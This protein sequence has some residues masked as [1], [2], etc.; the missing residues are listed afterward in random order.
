MMS[1]ATYRAHDGKLDFQ[2]VGQ[3]SFTISDQDP[4]FDPTALTLLQPDKLFNDVTIVGELEP[5][6]YVRDYFLGNGTTLD[7]YLSETPFVKTAI[8]IFEDDYSESQLAPTLW[9]VTDPNGAV[10]LSWRP[11]ATQ[12]RPVHHHLRRAAGT[13]R[14]LVMLQ[15]G[16][17]VFTAASTGT[18]GGIYNGSPPMPIAS[19]ASPSRPTAATPTFRRSINGSDN[20]PRPHHH[21]RSSVCFRHRTDL[22]RGPSHSSDLS[23]LASSRRQRSRRR[24]HPRS[25]YASSSPFTMS[26]PTIPAPSPQWPPC[27]TTTCFPR[28]PASPPM[29]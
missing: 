20:R 17:F 5:L 24:L 11:I 7:F 14:R 2:P 15:H 27:S 1:R 23:L 19:P 4:N 12:R 21:A 16:Q 10:S 6:N 29:R 13:R 22:Q 9:D 8:T 26:I 28:R 25:R 18:I 3:Q